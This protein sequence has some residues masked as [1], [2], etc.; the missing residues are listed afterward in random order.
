MLFN[1]KSP[2][3]W[4]AGCGSVDRQADRQTDIATYRLNLH[5]GQFSKIV[6]YT[7]W[8]LEHINVF[9]YY[10]GEYFTGPV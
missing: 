10:A 6:L 7:L 5:R 3:Q 4:E 8:L 2:V 1:Q 9:I